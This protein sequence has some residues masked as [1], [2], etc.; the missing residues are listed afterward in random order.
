MLLKNYLPAF[1]KDKNKLIISLLALFLLMIQSMTYPLWLAGRN[2][3]LVPIQ[4]SFTIIPASVHLILFVLILL[5]LFV[6]VIYPNKW[7]ASLALL[8]ELFSCMLDQNRWQPWEY[9]ALCILAAFVLIKDPQKQK[10]AW[11][12]IIIGLYFFSGVNKCNPQFVLNVWNGM[13]L[14]QYLGIEHSSIWVIRLGYLLALLEVLMGVGLLFKRFRKY[15]VLLIVAMHLFNLAFLGPLGLNFIYDVIPWNMAMPIFSIVLFYNQS[16]V[17]EKP[18]NWKSIYIILMALLWWIAPFFHLFGYWQKFFSA[19]LY[20]GKSANIYICTDTI[21]PYFNS[22]KYVVF[23]SPHADCSKAI[24][25]F[26]WGLA[27]IKV[28][29]YPSSK[30]YH[31]IVDYWKKKYP[32]NR[33]RFYLYDTDNKII[34]QELK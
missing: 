16:F 20:S 4:D 19:D 17:V 33:A 10:L 32:D 24:S 25:V 23:N 2:F 13:I 11:Q 12:I 31:A 14:H 34:K 18:A 3:P 7:V 21:P 5:A 9:F 26:K 28:V 15:A 8:F 29:F 30:S 1:V 27:D 6:L 22:N